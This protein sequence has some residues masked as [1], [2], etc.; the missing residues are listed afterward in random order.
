[1]LQRQ[2][3]EPT[4]SSINLPITRRQTT[5]NTI[6]SPRAFRL[7]RL[8]LVY[9][10]RHRRHVGV[11]LTDGRSF[12]SSVCYGTPTCMAATSWS[13]ESLS[14]GGLYSSMH[15]TLGEEENTDTK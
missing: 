2:S 14:I 12:I 10:L 9:A 3:S 4:V 1:M 5:N 13:F 7:F 8:F 6:E 11:P 15:G